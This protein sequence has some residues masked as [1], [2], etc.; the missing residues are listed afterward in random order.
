MGDS[1]SMVRLRAEGA[2]GSLK[3][4]GATASSLLIQP[5][6]ALSSISMGSG[7]TSLSLEKDAASPMAGAAAS[8]LRQSANAVILPASFC[9]RWIF[10][11]M[12]ASFFSLLSSSVM[13][14]VL[15]MPM[16]RHFWKRQNW[17]CFRVALVISHVLLCEQ[18]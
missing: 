15:F 4:P 9:R 18:K 8:S 1:R 14:H 2:G 3:D 5:K 16:S 7:L 10:L 12:A 17:Q 6:D 11:T 13:T